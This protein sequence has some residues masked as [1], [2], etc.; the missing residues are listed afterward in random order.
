[1]QK[2]IKTVTLSLALSLAGGCSY[3]GVYKRDLPQGNLV[4]QEMVAQLEQGMTR[5]QVKFVMGSPLLEA[6]FNANQ[7]DYLYRLDEAYGGVEQRRV[8]LTFA[9]DRLVNITSEGNLSSDIELPSYEGPGPA[10]E[11]T[12]PDDG[13]MSPQPT[14]PDGPTTTPGV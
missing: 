13:I 11:G 10:T 1:M 12:G 3:V 8:T 9:N 14:T 7:W 4:T 6:P 5:E 2:L